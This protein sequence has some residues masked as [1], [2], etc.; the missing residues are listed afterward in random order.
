MRVYVKLVIII[1][2]TSPHPK[3]LLL[4]TTAHFNAWTFPDGVIHSQIDHMLVGKEVFI[5]TD[6]QCYRFADC[7]DSDHYLVI[8]N[9]GK[10]PR[11]HNKVAFKIEK[12]KFNVK[13][14]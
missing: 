8:A 13:K 7:G 10:D 11:S 4:K 12:L 14:N 6:D 2:L 9:Q 1:R 3:I 5:V